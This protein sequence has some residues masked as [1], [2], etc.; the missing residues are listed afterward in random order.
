VIKF[1]KN[2]HRVGILQ[3]PFAIPPKSEVDAKRYIYNP[4]PMEDPPIANDLFLHYPQ[5]H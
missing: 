5:C 3:K 1:N 4:C 2:R